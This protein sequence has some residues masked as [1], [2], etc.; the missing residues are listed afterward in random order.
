[1]SEPIT[2]LGV[3]CEPIGKGAWRG[4]ST[5]DGRRLRVVAGFGATGGKLIAATW[6]CDGDR[7]TVALT[8]EA[9]GGTL[10]AAEERLRELMAVHLPEAWR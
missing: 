7:S 1:V 6:G 9:S 3:E 10:A 8:I 5:R 4:Y 2:I